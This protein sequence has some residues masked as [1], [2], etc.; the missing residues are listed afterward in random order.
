MSTVLWC[1]SAAAMLPCC[2]VCSA[3]RAAVPAAYL[4]HGAAR[5]CIKVRAFSEGDIGIK[6]YAGHLAGTPTGTQGVRVAGHSKENRLQ[7]RQKSL[8]F[9]HQFKVFAPHRRTAPHRAAPFSAKVRHPPHAP[10][11]PHRTAPHRTLRTAPP[12]F[13]AKVP[14]LPRAPPPP[15]RAPPRRTVL[16]K[17]STSPPHIEFTPLTLRHAAC[18][19]ERHAQMYAFRGMQKETRFAAC[20]NE[21]VSL[22]SSAASE[23]HP[24]AIPHSQMFWP[25]N[26]LQRC[27]CE[28]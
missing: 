14:H 25:Q 15:H 20:T 12:P 5:T 18:T 10:P 26:R 1:C 17:S 28:T 23:L 11:P 13:S 22:H 21:R 4:N 2:R 3:V 19:N 7:P 8:V 27:S 16:G 24:V 6:A 9:N